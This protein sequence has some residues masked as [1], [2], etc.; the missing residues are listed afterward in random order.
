MGKLTVVLQ[1][2]GLP[3]EEV[4]VTSLEDASKKVTEWQSARGLGASLLTSRHGSVREDGRYTARIAYNG[5]ILGSP[6][7][8]ERT[9]KRLVAETVSKTGGS[10]R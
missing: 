4:E 8:K 9:F 7:A 6:E 10:R 1:Q 5:K 3:A 2:V